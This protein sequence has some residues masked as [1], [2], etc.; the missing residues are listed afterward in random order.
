V[1]SELRKLQRAGYP[2]QA[3]TQMTLQWVDGLARQLFN[4]PI[5]MIIEQRL[6]RD[7]VYLRPSQFVS[8]HADH[9][10]SMDPLENE[11]VRTITPRAIF[12]HS[13]TLNNAYALFKDWLY[14]GTT[15]Y[16]EVYA[17]QP[18]ARQAQQ[19]FSAWQ[20]IMESFEP[21][22]EYDLVDEFADIL[23]LR[24][25]Y[26]W[27]TDSSQEA[28]PV[29]Q[30][31]RPEG[32]TNPELLKEKEMASVMYCLGALERFEG[33]SENQIRMIG[34]EIGLVGQDGIDYASPD[35]KY[36]IDSI[37]GES[38]TGL[39]LLCLMYVAFKQVEPSVDLG[40]DLDDA[41]QQA[42]TLHGS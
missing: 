1:G 32:T 28:S 3:I 30:P 12:R 26:L 27:R 17:K 35:R 21:G 42:L 37:P 6:Y 8:L 4:I 36:S 10:L 16:A 39:Q 2:E 13:V 41:Y 23:G 19:L 25:L 24:Q 33:M 31:S 34:F 14:S 15:K 29:S 38:F 11:D 18:Y 40:L 5:D 22:D 7:A 20:D 9:L